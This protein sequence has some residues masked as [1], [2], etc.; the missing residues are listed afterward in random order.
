MKVGQT[1]IEIARILGRYKLTIRQELSSG[2]GRRG[3]R[4]R[5]GDPVTFIK[6]KSI[7]KVQPLHTEVLRHQVALSNSSAN[8]LYF[9]TDGDVVAWLAYSA[10]G[11]AHLFTHH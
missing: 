7:P 8:F 1:Q 4:S 9:Y 3:Y 11:T 10:E 5:Q 2:S 6:V